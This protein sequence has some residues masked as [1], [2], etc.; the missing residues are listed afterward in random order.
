MEEKIDIVTSNLELAIRDEK[1]QRD[2]YKL[3]NIQSGVLCQKQGDKDFLNLIQSQIQINDN[4]RRNDN[5]GFAYILYFH[6]NL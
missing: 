1:D 2:Y 6:L 5:S 3:F 4:N